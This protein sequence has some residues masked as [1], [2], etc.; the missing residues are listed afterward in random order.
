MYRTLGALAGAMT[1][2]AALLAY[3]DPTTLAPPVSP[4][5]FARY[6]RA[7][8]AD[9]VPIDPRRW[10]QVQIVAAGSALGSGMPL[11]ATSEPDNAHFYVDAVGRPA[12]GRLWNR[13][14]PSADAPD[15]VRI[16]VALPRGNE[17][18]SSA[19]QTTVAALVVGLDAHLGTLAIR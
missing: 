17:V 18:L 3:F 7:L 13:Q 8:I 1:S 4:D 16:E 9:D 5:E 12:R 15:T 6:T 11:L 14:L 19:Q 2:T 10:R